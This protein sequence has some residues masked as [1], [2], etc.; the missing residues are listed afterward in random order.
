[1]LKKMSLLLSTR[2]DAFQLVFLSRLTPIPFG[3]QNSIF[4]ISSISFAEYLQASCLGLL[5]CQILNTYFG[6]TLRSMEEVANYSPKYF[7]RLQKLN[8]IYKFLGIW[9]HQY[10]QDWICCL[11]GTNGLCC[12]CLHVCHTECKETFYYIAI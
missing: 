12:H 5:P 3:L 11:N 8:I 6:S 2:K 9:R 4:A 1:M 7:Q 10:C